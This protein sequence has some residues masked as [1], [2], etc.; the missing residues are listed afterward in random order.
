MVAQLVRGRGERIVGAQPGARSL[1]FVSFFDPPPTMVVVL[2][3]F[4][5]NHEKGLSL[6]F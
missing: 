1:G 2:L 4:F 5:Q 3:A 6:L